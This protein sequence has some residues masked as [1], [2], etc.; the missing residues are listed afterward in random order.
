M[1]GRWPPP[2]LG[3]GSAVVCAATFLITEV[4]LVDA[5]DPIFMAACA[6]YRRAMDDSTGDYLPVSLA[7]RTDG[8]RVEGPVACWTRSGLAVSE[9]ADR[10]VPLALVGWR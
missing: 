1:L 3:G 5:R 8:R 2:A 10:G 9:I 6:S 7:R 4:G